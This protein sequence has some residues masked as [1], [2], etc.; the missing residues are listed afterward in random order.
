MK[1]N[2]LQKFISNNGEY[3]IGHRYVKGYGASCGKDNW[4]AILLAPDVDREY[5]V[6]DIGKLSFDKVEKFSKEEI[7]SIIHLGNNYSPF[8]YGIKREDFIELIKIT[9]KPMDLIVKCYQENISDY[10]KV[11]EVMKELTE[12]KDGKKE[13]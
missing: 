6:D 2:I 11:I 9:C 10:Y 13:D 3:L 5:W 4:E 12:K 7:K 1:R 8:Q